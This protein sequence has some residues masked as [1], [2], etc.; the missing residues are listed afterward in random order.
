MEGKSIYKSK[1]V[2]LKLCMWKA[3]YSTL[4]I[5]Y[6]HK[7]NGTVIHRLIMVDISRFNY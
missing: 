2:T 5:E 4:D 1:K 3:I 7:G 6:D